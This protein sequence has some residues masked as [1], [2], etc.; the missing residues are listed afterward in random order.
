MTASRDLEILVAKIQKQLAPRSEVL[1]DV[2]LLG[3]KSGI[4]R[5]IDVLVR[6]KVGQYDIQI[7]IDCKDHKDPVDIKGVE[8]FNG[9]YE[10]VGAQKAVLVAPR[11]FTAA[12]K[13]LAKV[14]QID[15]YSPVDTDAHK[16]QAIVSIPTIC[17][18]RSAL[19][20]VGLSSSVPLPLMIQPD[21]YNTNQIY[22][23]A[24]NS[25]GTCLAVAADKWNTGRWPIDTGVHERLPIFDV[26]ETQMD[27]GY[28]QIIPVDLWV[29]LYVEQQLYFGQAPVNKI[30][31]FHDH[32]TGLVIA[33]AFTVGMLD[34][35]EVEQ[36]WLKISKVEDAP[37]RPVIMLQGLVAWVQEI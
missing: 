37:V 18:Y 3:R 28:G 31:G 8:E 11:G 26:E 29:S 13:T 6:D 2:K 7:I 19:I 22:D 36:H 16:W 5:Q 20:S 15:L 23:A 4:M 27:N 32:H 33:N 30:S 10:D 34:V 24:G 12:A 35:D 14:L 9:L 21:F 17:D 25:L 1:H